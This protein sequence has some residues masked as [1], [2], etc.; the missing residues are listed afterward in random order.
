MKTYSIQHTPMKILLEPI[1]FQYNGVTEK[2]PAG[3]AFDWLSIPQIFQNVVNMNSTNNTLASLYHDYF[4]SLVCNVPITRKKADMRLLNDIE[5][6]GRYLIYIGVRLGGWYSWKKD[7]NYKKY[8][9][10]IDKAR[11]QLFSKK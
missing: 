2:I 4:Y 1:Y 11:K 5:G 9:I 6:L 7:R 8:K 3:Y 10:Q